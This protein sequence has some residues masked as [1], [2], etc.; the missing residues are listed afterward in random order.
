MTPGSTY[1]PATF[2][3]PCLGREPRL[4]LR[5]FLNH[6]ILQI[7][8]VSLSCNKLLSH[9]LGSIFESIGIVISLLVFLPFVL[10]F[11]W[12]KRDFVISDN[13]F[14]NLAFIMRNLVHQNRTHM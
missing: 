11:F 12:F 14:L 13:P 9:F 7:F 2:Q 4:G 1:R 8:F 10:I 3:P 5:H 6:L